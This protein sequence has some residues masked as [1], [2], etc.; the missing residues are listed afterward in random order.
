MCTN[1]EDLARLRWNEQHPDTLWST[2]DPQARNDLILWQIEEA[3]PAQI[4]AYDE[5]VGGQDE[6]PTIIE[7][8]DVAYPQYNIAFESG[9]RG[10][11]AYQELLI[12]DMWAHK[13][14]LRI[15]QQKAAQILLK[16]RATP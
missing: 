15:D 10:D 9:N 13:I 4:I 3:T 16:E 12:V 7:T 6:M 2:L 8:L 11:V 1:F 5:K 14:A